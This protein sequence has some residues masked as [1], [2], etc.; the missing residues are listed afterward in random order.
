MSGRFLKAKLSK[1]DRE[2]ILLLIKEV[3]L[4]CKDVEAK[5]NGDL[6]STK[7]TRPD[8]I[9]YFFFDTN[10]VLNRFYK[11]ITEEWE[12]RVYDSIK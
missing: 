3:E 5:L 4:S 2:E 7:Q 6:G 9:Q 8:Y 11:L 12:N 10:S 1:R